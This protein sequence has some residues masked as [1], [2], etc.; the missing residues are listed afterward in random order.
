MTKEEIRSLDME[1]LEERAE[2]IAEEVE[3]AETD[4]LDTLTEELETIEE[5]KSEIKAEAEERKAA[6]DAVL[7][8]KGEEIEKVEEERKTMDSKE[9]RSMPEYIEAYA[10]YIKGNNDGTE[11]RSL[12]TTN[13]VIGSDEFG[14][15]PVP[16]YIEERIQGAWENDGIMSRVRRTFIR[17]NV[18]VGA[19]LSASGAVFHAE[20]DE[21]PAEE[22][23]VLG[24]VDIVAQS[25]KKWITVSD[26]ALA[27]TGQAFLDYLY[28]EIEYQIVKAE[29]AKV[30]ETIAT[31]P[32]SGTTAPI[33]WAD[34]YG[35]FT[36]FAEAILNAE[37]NAVGENLVV[38]A[39]RGTIAAIKAEALGAGYAYDPFDGMTVIPCDSIPSH[40]DAQAT[41]PIIIV[42]DLSAIQAN[43]P[44][45]GEVS[46]KFDDL[47]LAEQDLVKIVGRQMCGI[48]LVRTK[49]FG[50]ILEGN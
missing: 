13:A 30:I 38:M 31:A 32:T 47:S 43:F 39:N 40:A 11:C 29:A 41:D 45:G 23:L 46:F 48:G 42:G 27:L 12:L 10:E 28:D 26:E 20:G 37:G 25:V 19:E 35:T 16:T 36:S 24:I 49:A 15:V 18:R 7:E 21:A 33:V 44:E 4:A 14:T 17:G 50:V 6:M 8:G 22:T 2:A 9:V 5:R 1:G 34:N 3:T